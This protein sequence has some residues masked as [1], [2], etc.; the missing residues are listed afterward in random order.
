MNRQDSPHLKLQPTLL[1]DVTWTGGFWKKKFGLV[2]HNTLP[3]MWKVFKDKETSHAWENF[4]IA[5]GQSAGD[6]RGTYWIDGDFYKC[7]EASAYIYKETKDESLDKVM[8]QAIELIAAAQSAN[9]YLHTPVTIGHG[10]FTE[11]SWEER[12]DHITPFSNILHHELYCMGHLLTA[13]CV[14]YQATGK[15]TLLNV[16][17]KCGLFLWNT[18]KTR[19]SK[20]ANFGFNPSYIMGAVDLYRVTQ[21]PEF[22]QLAV[23]FLE[24]RGSHPA[25]RN[26][27][28][29]K[30][31]LPA[32]IG[33]TDFTQDRVPF[34]EENEAVGH[35]VTAGYLFCGA[36]DIFAETG[37]LSILNKL[38]ELW[39]DVTQRKMYITGGS[40]AVHKGITKNGDFAQEMYGRPYELPNATAY[41]ETCAN[42]SNAMWAYRMLGIT[43]DAKYAD[44]IERVLYNSALSGLSSCGCKYFYTNPMERFNDSPMLMWDHEERQS[45]MS[46]FCCPP[47][48][49]RTVA[50]LGRWAYNRSTEGLW[51]N[52]YGSNTLNTQ[53]NDNCHIQLSQETKYPWE[54]KVKITLEEVSGD[55]DIAIFLRIPAWSASTN[56]KVNG[57]VVECEKTPNAYVPIKRTWEKGDCVELDL[58][59]ETRLVCAQPAVESARN[60]VA[61]SRGP[62]IYCVESKDIPQKCSIK[63]LYIP[64]DI[65]L[66]AVFDEQ[67]C[68]GITKLAGEVWSEA[69]CPSSD[70]LYYNVNNSPNKLQKISVKFIPYYAWG[71]RGKSEMSVWNRLLLKVNK[72]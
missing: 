34:L 50:G 48:I 53:V 24:N 1:G 54:G 2:R 37:D 20:L 66:Q 16:A 8:D 41:N 32:V 38:V 44:L 39:N 43:G 35:A 64:S 12:F 17:E 11:F 27:Y 55:G 51:V 3:S 14:H 6:F 56:I 49:A 25:Q 22:L 71:N 42:I 72:T 58:E 63:E 18:F 9:G 40:G 61:V 33:G 15:H 19:D 30:D 23:I 47:S 57:E 21:N 29:T 10:Y 5:A 67:C 69:R 68:G 62:I 70:T 13:G 46:C 28:K 65:Q 4:R 60:Q 26:Q 59:M 31:D 52:L 45:Y 7:I 36:A